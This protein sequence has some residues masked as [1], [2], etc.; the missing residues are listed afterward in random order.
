M[1]AT[2]EFYDGANWLPILLGALQGTDNQITVTQDPTTKA[3]T[4]SIATNPIL[5]GDTTINSTGFL[6]LPVGTE[7]ER[8]ATPEAGMIRFNNGS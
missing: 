5:P 4:L 6:K 8:P 7:A 3:F 1:P 2:I